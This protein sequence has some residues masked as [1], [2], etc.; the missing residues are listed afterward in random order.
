MRMMLED[1]DLWAI[2]GNPCG[3]GGQAGDEAEQIQ[4]YLL[5]DVRRDH[6]GDAGLRPR[7]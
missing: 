6:P 7:V 4:R 2:P 5:D 3:V 1:A